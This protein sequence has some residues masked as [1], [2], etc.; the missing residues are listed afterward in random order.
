[1]TRYISLRTTIGKFRHNEDGVA[2]VEFALLFPIM[3]L[4]FAVIIEGSR[5]FWSYQATI[6]GVRDATRYVGRA[7][8][9]DICETGGSLDGMNA[10]LLAMVSTSTGG[11]G[12]FPA[13]V[14]VTGVT[15]SLNCA[16]NVPAYRGG[17][18]PVA[19]LS[20]T[21]T[22]QFPFSGIFQLVGGNLGTV[23]TTVTDST[24][25]HGI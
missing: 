20:A 22:I 11:G 21:L 17:Q 25:I 19:T 1:M 6:S 8:P 4:I 15:T 2:L 7:A 13:G 16:T 12:V 9:R 23:N 3:L 18:V 14:T 5:T 10:A 24:R